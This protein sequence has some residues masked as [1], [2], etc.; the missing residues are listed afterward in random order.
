MAIVNKI[1]LWRWLPRPRWRLIGLIEEADQVPRKLPNN[2]A[3]LV[4]ST[5]TPKW[6][7]FDCPCRTGHRI[8]LDME[9][10]RFPHWRIINHGRL[11]V[12]PSIDIEIH[13][14][15]CHYLIIMG[16]TIWIPNEELLP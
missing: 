8:M 11:T 5:L 7:V 3:I 9:P 15:R 6:L 10:T 16:R 4:G 2:G 12:L 1:N 13:E 14:R